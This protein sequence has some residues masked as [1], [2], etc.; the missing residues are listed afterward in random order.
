[1]LDEL[2]RLERTAISGPWR[3]EHGS[4]NTYVLS[5]S[6]LHVA[7]CAWQTREMDQESGK[8]IVATRNALPAL[9]AVAK[10][11]RRYG[12]LSGFSCEYVEG[13]P[14]ACPGVVESD[15][16]CHWCEMRA[17]LAALEEEAPDAR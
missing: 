16:P 12:D 15:G 8:F 11:L 9:L 4:F 1:M 7:S 10:A 14:D 2:E 13:E 6:G 3:V 5:N 17:A